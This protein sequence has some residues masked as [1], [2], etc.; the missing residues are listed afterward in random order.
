MIVGKGPAPRLAEEEEREE[1]QIEP[2]KAI[3]EKWPT[4]RWADEGERK[5]VDLERVALGKGVAPTRAEGGSKDEE[6]MNDEKR[7]KEG[8]IDNNKRRDDDKRAATESEG[9]VSR[10]KVTFSEQTRICWKE[11][12]EEKDNQAKGGDEP[13]KGGDKVTRAKRPADF[14]GSEILRELKQLKLNIPLGH[15]LAL[16][17]DYREKLLRQLE[18]KKEPEEEVG[19]VVLTCEVDLTT[20]WDMTVPEVTVQIN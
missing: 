4:P 10:Q 20:D 9:K 17:L 14:N 19:S 2:K 15:L 1:R 18:G 6:G 16:V 3:V 12:W 5:R 11:E 7:E 8:G 13:V